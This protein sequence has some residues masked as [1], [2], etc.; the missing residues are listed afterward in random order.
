MKASI[1][2]KSRQRDARAIAVVV[3]CPLARCVAQA[4]G[5]IAVPKARKASLAATQREIAAGARATLRVKLSPATRTAVKRALRTRKS[6][7][8]KV[9][10]TVAGGDGLS[11]RRT[12]SVHLTR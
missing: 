2:A 4:G 6:I 9:S 12:L 1:S 7:A 5:T 11:Q 10:V 8:A 3:G